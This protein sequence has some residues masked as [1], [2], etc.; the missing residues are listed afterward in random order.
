M[1]CIN[2]IKHLLN[3]V[4]P[5]IDPQDPG[6]NDVTFALFTALTN[7]ITANTTSVCCNCSEDSNFPYVLTTVENF[8]ILAEVLRILPG[9]GVFLTEETTTGPIP[10]NS[11]CEI[12]EYK[13]PDNFLSYVDTNSPVVGNPNQNGYTFTSNKVVNWVN[14]SKIRYTYFEENS[15]NCIKDCCISYFSSVENFLY[16]AE[17]MLTEEFYTSNNGQ[18]C[19]S[20]N[21]CDSKKEIE[22]YISNLKYQEEVDRVMDR[23]IIEISGGGIKSLNDFFSVNEYIW[24]NNFFEVLMDRGVVSYCMDDKVLICSVELFIQYVSEGLIKDPFRK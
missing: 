5:L 2:S 7:G 13:S 9:S 19:E 3:I 24:K 4:E 11:L 23:G 12:I 20:Y 8:I 15:R 10:A 22:K 1:S 16:Y 18:L 21:C 6:G 14:G 17:A